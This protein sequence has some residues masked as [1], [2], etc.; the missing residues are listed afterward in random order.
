MRDLVREKLHG[1][2]P[3]SDREAAV[4]DSGFSD[5]TRGHSDDFF[6]EIPSFRPAAVLVPLVDHVDE[7]TVLLT[8]RPDYMKKHA[9]QVAFP[10]GGI[11]EQ[12]ENAIAAA[13]R[14][15]EEEV[16]LR[17]DHVEIVGQLDPYRT[18]TG[19]EISPIV[20]I[21]QPEFELT[22]CEVEVAEAFEV[23]LS[24]LMDPQNRKRHQ[25]EYRGKKRE[26]YSM[27]YED[28]NIWGA[29]AGMLVN[30]SKRL[31]G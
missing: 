4:S 21:V 5:L 23:P 26:Y 18:G 9:G 1:T 2:L 29:T 13:L 7:M 15:A 6:D 30:L 16:G 12:D 8:R 25:G 19:Y 22:I 14:E 27:P 20:G 31:Y 10:G 24:F 28:Y 17:P 11:D 3:V